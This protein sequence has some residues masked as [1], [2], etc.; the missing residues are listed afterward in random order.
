MTNIDFEVFDHILTVETF[1]SDVKTVHFLHM[2]AKPKRTSE[3][4]NAEMYNTVI[5]EFNYKM[6]ITIRKVTNVYTTN[7]TV[8]HE[9]I[10]GMKFSWIFVGRPKNE[11]FMQ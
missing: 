5:R 9:N 7:T 4:I 11:N 1:F 6:F 2:K 10:R 8:L 3:V